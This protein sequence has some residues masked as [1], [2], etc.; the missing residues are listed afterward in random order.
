[1]SI[2]KKNLEKIYKKGFIMK[3]H[4]WILLLSSY[5]TIAMAG[6][7]LNCYELDALSDNDNAM[8]T[9]I[10]QT[11]SE[12]NGT[13][14][15]LRTQSKDH[16]EGLEALKSMQLGWMKMRDSQC[17]FLS[18]HSAGGGGAARTAIR[19]EI[20][21]TIKREEELSKLLGDE[22]EEQTEVPVGAPIV[23]GHT[24]SDS[25]STNNI[26][27]ASNF[28]ANQL[29]FQLKQI[30]SSSIQV[31]AGKNYKLR[32]QM[33]NGEIYDVVIYEDLQNSM[34]L[35]SSKKL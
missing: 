14:N 6:T 3:K 21:M 28:A 27:K 25:S 16:K 31:V 29:G 5:S 20:E 10:T 15:A 11:N 26:Q 13:Y 17:L 34:K 30:L 9:C 7:G 19:C 23:G 35:T 12:L 2:L 33:K 8:E 22:P 32:L 1:M 18:M 4:T 24:K